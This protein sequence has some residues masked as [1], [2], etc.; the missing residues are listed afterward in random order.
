SQEKVEAKDSDEIYEPEA[1]VNGIYGMFSD[2]NYGF[3]FLGITEIISDN[4]DKGSSPTDSG[5]DKDILDN[6]TYTST[7]G[8]F[9]A[10]W[11]HWYKSIG[12]A[13]QAIEYIEEFGLTDAA[14][15]NRLTG[16]ARFLRALN[17]FY[18]VRGWGD[19]P[20]QE[21]DLI[22]RKPASEVY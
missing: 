17:Y 14:Y 11:E 13:S 15:K 18:L 16:E 22:E 3:S 4:A 8:S 1:F 10:M 20:I 2:W 21:I 12:R 5:S 9:A 7:A 19:I 6:L